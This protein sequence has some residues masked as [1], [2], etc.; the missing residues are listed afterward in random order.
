MSGLLL[1]NPEN[2]LALA[3]GRANY[4]PPPAAVRLRRSGSTLPLWYG[5]ESDYAITEGVN[6]RW[7]GHK[8]ELF[9]IP[10]QLYSGYDSGM[11]PMPW[12]W[13]ANARH[14]FELRGVP[15]AAL[16]P[17]SQ[18]TKIRELSHRRSS[19]LIGESL[20]AL[21]P[22]RLAQ[23]AKELDSFDAVKAYADGHGGCVLKL[24]WSSS[25]RGVIPVIKAD[26][27]RQRAQIEG[28][29]RRQGSVMAEPIYKKK[30]DFALLYMMADGKCIY[31]GMS[32][33]DTNGFGT[34]DGNILATEDEL[35]AMVCKS[36]GGVDDLNWVRTAFP[37]ILENLIGT[38]YIGP[39]G[40][41]MM[42]VEADDFSLVPAVELNLRMT[43]GH[44]CHRFYR[45]YI[46]PGARGRFYI[47]QSGSSG[48]EDCKVENSRI[49]HGFIDLA[50]P[51]SDFSFIV[52]V[53]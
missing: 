9:G 40:I 22:G 32:V 33:F 38:S 24:P 49:S 1:F 37:G 48:G 28:M 14:M 35:N 2:D 36:L 19:A 51:G 50:Q 5:G 43:M 16:P 39:L 8:K 10:V 21:R 34:Y 23:A 52:S 42:A 20:N 31:E 12:G 13:S 4:T 3:N 45:D 7:Y 27:D 11:T 6:A 30:L 17:D 47:R 29:I 46:T 15:I 41:D 44:L 25:G 18:L 26:V 53:D